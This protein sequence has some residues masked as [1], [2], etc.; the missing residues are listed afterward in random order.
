MSIVPARVFAPQQWWLSM[1]I[2]WSL[3]SSMDPWPIR[4]VQLLE[5]YE[6]HLQRR[7]E[8]CKLLA[9]ACRDGNWNDSNTRWTANMRK[10]IQKTWGNQYEQVHFMIVHNSWPLNLAHSQH[11]ATK[12]CFADNP[13][14]LK[15]FRPCGHAD[16]MEHC[17]VDPCL[18]GSCWNRWFNTLALA[19]IAY[20]RVLNPSKPMRTRRWPWIP[21]S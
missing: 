7:D 20:R 10:N 18:L 5:L 17:V 21:P 9:G 12:T 15:C 14:W 3:N 1:T 2:P 16:P 11:W 8:V 4:A 19:A 13:T 6:V